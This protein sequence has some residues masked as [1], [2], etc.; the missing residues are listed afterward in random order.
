LAV[1]PAFK[2]DLFISYAHADDKAWN[3]VTTFQATLK[4]ELL[5]K[6][7][8]FTIWWDTSLRTGE[9]FDLAIQEAISESAAFLCILS[10]AYGQSTYCQNEVEWFRRRIHPTFGLTVETLSRM[11]GIVIDKDFTKDRWPAE[12]RGTTP[13]PFFSESIP[14]FSRPKE[15]DSA[16]PWIQSLWKIRDSIWDLLDKMRTQ[17][18]R[19]TPIVNPYVVSA[20]TGALPTA[21]L[22]EV[23]DDLDQKRENLRTSLQGA[24]F[25]IVKWATATPPST[26]LGVLSVHLFGKYQKRPSPGENT[27]LPY[28]QLEASIKANP[29]RHPL[30]WL[31][32][33]LDIEQAEPESH[34]EFLRK[35]LNRNDI[36]LLRTDFEDLKEEV[37]KRLGKQPIQIRQI[38]EDPIVHIWHEVDDPAS[39]EPLKAYLRQKNCAISIFK[40]S[41]EQLGK[42]QSRLAI[43]DGLV[44]P[45]AA[46]KKTW[47]EDVMA[48]AFLIRRREERPLA[49]AAVELPPP[50]TEQFNFLHPR[51]VPVH[52]GID[53]HEMDG[54][55]SKLEDHV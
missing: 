23:P 38:R 55:F 39:L 45:Y 32:R 51:V 27:S 52:A 6:N 13:C 26:G 48:E 14:L 50:G 36:E 20:G 41:S 53:F 54:F 15:F 19:G 47:A 24:K 18:D 8:D 33:D 7:R 43:C 21:Y 35:L 12:L 17:L 5:R 16:S 29:A 28:V 42:L 44:V 10:P 30:V 31:A 25:E 46:H 34:K 1:V 40:Y 22:A 2:H 9:R 3:W 4:D 11:Q 37:G 49:F